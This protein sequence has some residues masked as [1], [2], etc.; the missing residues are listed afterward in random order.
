MS[1]LEKTMDVKSDVKSFV[2]DEVKRSAFSFMPSS[3]E[4]S[5]DYLAKD[6]NVKKGL[7]AS[8]DREEL[9]ECVKE[10]RQYFGLNKESGLVSKLYQSANRLGYV[11]QL[12]SDAV[13]IASAAWCWP[14]K[15]GACLFRVATD[16]LYA[17]YYLLNTGVE[18]AKELPKYAAQKILGIIPGVTAVD[19]MSLKD[20]Q[21]WMA[22]SRARDNFLKRKELYVPLHSK[23]GNILYKGADYIKSLFE[24]KPGYVKEPVPVPA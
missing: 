14:V 11:G 13:V 2:R 10:A 3:L 22:L 9:L 17:P 7:K 19:K 23:I 4:D 15:L 16:A 6:Y 12:A 24:R 21:N 1:S 18:G 5:L 20:R 8:G